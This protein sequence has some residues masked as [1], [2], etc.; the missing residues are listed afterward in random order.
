MK[1]NTLTFTSL[2]PNTDSGSGLTRLSK[3]PLFEKSSQKTPSTGS[4][5]AQKSPKCCLKH[6]KQG[7]FQ[8]FSPTFQR[9]VFEKGLFRQFQR[10][11]F[12]AGGVGDCPTDHNQAFRSS[13]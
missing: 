8:C 2:P 11:A 4:K 3:K 10:L 9:S 1:C 6:I 7:A 5:K 12:L 13:L